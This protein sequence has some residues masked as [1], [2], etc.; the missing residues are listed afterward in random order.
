MKDVLDQHHSEALIEAYIE[1]SITETESRQLKALLAEKPEAVDLILQG[2][3][4][5]HFIRTV[6][7]E[8]AVTSPAVVPPQ[9]RGILGS[10]RWRDLLVFPFQVGLRRGLAAGAVACAGLILVGLIWRF[11]PV[12]GEPVLTSLQ[13]NGVSLERSGKAEVASDGMRLQPGDVLR[14]P[15]GAS[16]VISYQP[17][18]TRL[19]IEP[20]T[21]ITL[22]SFAHGKR[23]QLASGQIEASVARQRPFRAMIVSTLEAEARVVGTRFTLIATNNLTR[24]EVTEGKV[25]FTRLID[26][27][28]VVVTSG[29]YA[30][31]ATN[32]L[33]AVQPQTGRILR[34]YWTNVVTDLETP[35]ESNTNYPGHPSGSE[36]LTRFEVAPNGAENFV[37]RI[38]G[39]LHPPTTGS[40][41][42]FLSGDDADSLWLSRDDKA[43]RKM[44]IGYSQGDEPG[45]WAKSSQQSL[46]LTAGKI[47]YIEVMRRA[48]RGPNRLTVAWRP[49]G[50][51]IEII[52]G[53]FLSPFK[54]IGKENQR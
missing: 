23:F 38:Y 25:L 1:G 46:T 6:A 49:P 7:A 3:R 43:Q 35:F 41:A 48:G 11:G 44:V 22:G 30:V 14:T 36:Y 13:G 9:R 33:L 53:E 16:G 18:G 5:E 52:P 51:Q 2:L 39:Y 40:Y 29:H 45:Q 20:G 26:S 19:T 31:A 34:E 28:N 42:F 15:A 54:S 17:E 37:D 10:M 8:L 47:Y 24:L 21:E 4:D 50:G 27:T 12:S 32:Y